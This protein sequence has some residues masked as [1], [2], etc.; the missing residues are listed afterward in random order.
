MPEVAAIFWVTKA[1]TTAMGEAAS[2]FL[3]RAMAPEIAVLL[4]AV[5][6]T[7]AL[8]IQLRAGRYVVWRYWFAVA[9]VGVFGTM[10][11]DV[12]HV[13]LG[14]P[15]AVSTVAFAIALAA[16]FGAWRSSEK[17]LSIHSI[18]TRRRELFYW[19]AVMATFALGTAA[20]DLVAVTLHLG[21]LAAALVFSA[22]LLV[23]AIG[24]R[25]FGMNAVLAFWAAYVLTRPVGA[26]FADWLGQPPVRGGLGIGSGRV[27]LV[28][29]LAIG[30]LVVRMTL[31]QREDRR[32]LA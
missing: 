8:V 16:V 24:Y 22:L 13:G 18:H 29:S 17:T 4:G 31:T 20:G 23:P 32:P 1:L 10:A 5:A 27:A 12:V 30:A 19:A 2:D 14:I 11:A 9:M 28:L 21:Y 7:V 15:Y 6:F 25:W 3:V 26:S